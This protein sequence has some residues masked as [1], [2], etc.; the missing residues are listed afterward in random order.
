MASVPS[1][2]KHTSSPEPP[3]SEDLTRDQIEE[4][5]DP[6][7]LNDR[8]RLSWAL[9]TEARVRLA[10]LRARDT[11]DVSHTLDSKYLFDVYPDLGIQPKHRDSEDN[12]APAEDRYAWQ[13]KC[14]PCLEQSRH[15][16]GSFASIPELDMS[17]HE[18]QQNFLNWD[19]YEYESYELYRKAPVPPNF[20]CFKII[21]E[22]FLGYTWPCFHSSDPELP[23]CAV[24][25]G[26]VVA[27]LTAWRDPEVL[28]LFEAAQLDAWIDKRLKRNNPFFEEYENRKTQLLD[29]LHNWF[30]YNGI[31]SRS[32]FSTG[33]VDIF[34]QASSFTRSLTRN[35]KDLGLDSDIRERVESFIGGCGYVQDDLKRL[36]D[37]VFEKVEVNRRW[38]S[39]EEYKYVFS[40]IDPENYPEDCKM[41]FALTQNALSF[42]MTSEVDPETWGYGDWA[43]L[44]K[45]VFWPRNTQLIRLS[46]KADLVGGLM[47]FDISLVACSYDGNCVRITPRAAFSLVTLTQIVTPF[48][49]EEKRNWQRIVK[50]SRS[51]AWSDPPSYSHTT[52][53]WHS[54]TREDFGHLC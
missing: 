27:A 43:H 42:M 39:R 13:R 11:L 53:T 16:D 15:P 23:R 17:E 33:D 20:L 44:R 40:G 36:A 46:E 38:R 18:R 30:Q 5:F 24:Q 45:R 21:L 26:A 19:E 2:R 12:V 48:I 9:Q 7:L 28:R 41:V 50:V 51:A 8:Q 31:D 37:S 14:H 47:D 49:L 3:P 10:K 6:T 29:E 34:L 35:L 22:A 52:C 4:F 1:K 25:G 32:V 54:T